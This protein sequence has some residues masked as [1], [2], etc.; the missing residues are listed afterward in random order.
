MSGIDEP[1]PPPEVPEE[2]AAV[3]R[4]A[5]R[6]A[7]DESPTDS[8]EDE[9]IPLRSSPPRPRPTRFGPLLVGGV[10]VLAICVALGVALL[11]GGDEPSTGEPAGA[12]ASVGPTPSPLPTQ[13][14]T[15]SPPEP[16]ASPRAAEAWDG[17]VTPVAALQVT[18]SCTGAASVDA[19]GTRVEYPAENAT[20]GDPATAWRCDDEAIGE[21]L[22]LVL[23]PGTEVVEVGLIPGYAKTDPVSGADRYR[24][25]NRVTRVR[26]T[27][28]DGT[29]IVQDLDPADRSVQTQRLPRTASGTLTL[30]ILAIE[31]GTRNRTAVSEIAVAQAP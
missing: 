23:P 13:A 11:A 22:T 25:N 5:Y 28:E 12:G 1:G 18:A 6:R 27:L 30:E 8:S 24:E 9:L 19:A 17:P 4:D 26:W 15:T 7:L 16:S 14:A 2:Y 20:D 31:R 29:E 3:Y 10:V 21:T